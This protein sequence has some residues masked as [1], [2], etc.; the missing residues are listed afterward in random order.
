VEILTLMTRSATCCCLL[1]PQNTTIIRLNHPACELYRRTYGARQPHLRPHP[2]HHH[3]GFAPR[4]RRCPGRLQLP[5]A[6]DGLV[7]CGCH[8]HA[9][10]S[11]L[12]A[13]RIRALP[14]RLS[15][16]VLRRPKRD[17]PLHRARHRRG[18]HLRILRRLQAGKTTPQRS[19]Q[20]A[21]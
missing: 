18:R 9:G 3:L 17:V 12:A 15:A 8:G 16:E 14:S 21:L 19:L 1:S 2:V 5:V 11:V 13:L 7:L 10:D 4:H 6:A 20:H